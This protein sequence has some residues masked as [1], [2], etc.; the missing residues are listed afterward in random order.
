METYYNEL[1]IS[2][3]QSWGD[4]HSF[5]KLL[6]AKDS[7][8]IYIGIFKDAKYKDRV[9]GEIKERNSRVLFTIKTVQSLQ[10][11]LSIFLLAAKALEG[12]YTYISN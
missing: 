1:S 4:T 10:D 8:K 5:L 3:L 7:N 6:R 9:T 11:Q 2:E 12:V